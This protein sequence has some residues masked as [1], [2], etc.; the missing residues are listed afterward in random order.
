M[1]DNLGEN[2]FYEFGI[3]FEK[4]HLGYLKTQIFLEQLVLKKKNPEQMILLTL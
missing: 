1:P 3:Y 2:D 4:G